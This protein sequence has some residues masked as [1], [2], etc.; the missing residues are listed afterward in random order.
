MN[1]F[2]KIITIK[3]GKEA[4]EFAVHEALLRRT[5]RFFDCA[6]KSKWDVSR[7]ETPVLQLTE[8]DPKV[9]SIYVH[10]LYF[11]MLPTVHLHISTWRKKVGSEADILVY[12]YV[13][14]EMLHDT[15]Y[16]NAVLEA[17][18]NILS[19]NYPSGIFSALSVFIIN[20]IYNNTPA[21][22]P[23]RRLVVDTWAHWATRLCEGIFES[24][25]ADFVKD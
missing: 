10:W 18:V 11:K 3:I 16:R 19:N 2:A 14:G 21:G 4:T 25:P 1:S 20:I 8:E 5:F 17:S 9:F 23:A 7:G 22:S 15:E 12:S 6:L 24:L 13:M